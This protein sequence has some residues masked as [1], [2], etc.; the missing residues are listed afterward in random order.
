[1]PIKTYIEKSYIKATKGINNYKFSS[2][3]ITKPVKS[4]RYHNSYEILLS[5]SHNLS[6]KDNDK[7]N[8][9]ELLSLSRTKYYD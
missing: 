8:F 1:M 5:N 3:T 6:I 9:N 4:I 2:I 7:E